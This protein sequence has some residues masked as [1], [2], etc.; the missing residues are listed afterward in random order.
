MFVYTLL[1][2]LFVYFAVGAASRIR[3]KES[4]RPTCLYC[5]LAPA[6]GGLQSLKATTRYQLRR[7]HH[8]HGKL[9][10]LYKQVPCHSLKSPEKGEGGWET[11]RT[12]LGQN[13]YAKRATVYVRSFALVAYLTLLSTTTRLHSLS[14]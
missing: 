1:F 12:D 3:A 7:R 4:A 8:P 6:M 14:V 11:S 2:I 13:G 9:A 5:M 10:I